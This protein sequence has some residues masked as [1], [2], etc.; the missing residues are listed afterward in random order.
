MFLQ[1][2]LWP[3]RLPSGV[4]QT[5]SRVPFPQVLG[6]PLVASSALRTAPEPAQIET[7]PKN[8]S[9]QHHRIWCWP[10]GSV[11]QGRWVFS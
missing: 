11:R 8:L 6:S 9:S 4:T 7:L 5:G 2:L 10:A 1:R 3:I